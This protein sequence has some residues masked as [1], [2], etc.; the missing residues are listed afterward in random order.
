M[1]DLPQVE[2]ILT[3]MNEVGISSIK[4]KKMLMITH[5]NE[6]AWDLDRCDTIIYLDRSNKS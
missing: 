5:S 6:V 4:K 3:T 2:L 1:L